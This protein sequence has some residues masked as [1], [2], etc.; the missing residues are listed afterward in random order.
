MDFSM[1]W[2]P[3]DNSIAIDY[4]SIVGL[5]IGSLDFFSLPN[6][7][8]QIAEMN[9]TDPQEPA[10]H[11]A[12]DV[13]CTRNAMMALCDMRTSSSGNHGTPWNDVSPGAV[14][15]YVSSESPHS[16][17]HTTSPSTAPGGLYATSFNGARMPCTTR[18]RRASRLIPGA[19]PIRP[20]A[21]L[22]SRSYVEDEGLEFP[23]TSHLLVNTEAILT[24]SA[25]HASTTLTKPVYEKMQQNYTRLCLGE[26]VVF[27][28]YTSSRYP[29]LSTLNTFVQLYF[30][31][32]DIVLP[33]LHD[34]VT[35]IND[36]WILA[37]A[38][39]AVGC[40]YAEA[41]EFSRT[42]EPLHEFLRRAIMV[43]FTESKLHNI[44]Q[45]RYGV[46]L[47]QAMTLSQVGMLYFGSPRLLH[48][49]K[50]QHGAIIALARTLTFQATTSDPVS[51]PS[52][53]D[54]SGVCD[55]AWRK[56]IFEECKCRVGY[57]IWVST[58]DF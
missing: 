58:S 53:L 26:G 55:S 12:S 17:T 9:T 33:I 38:V 41:D 35:H 43:D 39:C 8:T 47:A 45:D 2:L 20:L 40:Q 27:Q 13:N 52:E 32:F 42:V 1:N 29:D 11:P 28:C 6:S 44:G 4:D 57:A 10:E 19:S 25:P 22:R 23:D 46:A 24:N 54:A 7:S 50:V 16:A 37:L 14:E 49:A 51:A 31:N 3:P 34:Q 21:D 5:G 36:H 15:S 48:Y 30:D 56:L 18:A